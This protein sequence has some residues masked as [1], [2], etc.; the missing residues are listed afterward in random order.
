MSKKIRHS[1]EVCTLEHCGRRREFANGLCSTHGKRKRVNDPNWDRPLKQYFSR[2]GKCRLHCANPI[3]KQGLCQTHYNKSRQQLPNWDASIRPRKA[4]GEGGQFE[5][6]RVKKTTSTLLKR[7]AQHR[8][9]SEYALCVEILDLYAECSSNAVRA[10]A[11]D[12][13]SIADFVRRSPEE[14]NV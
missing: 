5:R 11:F 13:I 2:T 7:T 3:S 10:N 8:G 12:K 6:F 4:N 9:M 14:I 1:G